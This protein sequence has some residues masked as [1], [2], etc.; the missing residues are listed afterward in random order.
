M[1]GLVETVN[2]R[3]SF[4]MIIDRFIFYPFVFKFVDLPQ[5]NKSPIGFDCISYI[6]LRFLHYV[7]RNEYRGIYPIDVL[8]TS[9][10]RYSFQKRAT[11]LGV[12]K[13]N[14]TATNNN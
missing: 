14:A 5:L 12:V 4:G 13:W 8:L 11:Q 9:L 2:Y 3:N 6:L 7:I 1:D 10:L